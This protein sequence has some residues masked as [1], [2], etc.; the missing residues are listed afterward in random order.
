MSLK[1]LCRDRKVFDIV[2]ARSLHNYG[3][4]YT[5]ATGHKLFDDVRGVLKGISMHHPALMA[6][7][8]R[9]S[10][11]DF[12]KARAATAEGDEAVLFTLLFPPKK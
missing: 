1:E 2:F 5:K 9:S 7:A 6:E 11:M 3:N 12:R 4:H 10:E 8:V